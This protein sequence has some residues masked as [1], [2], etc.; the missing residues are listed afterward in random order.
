MD[1][2]AREDTYEFS[3]MAHNT[4]CSIISPILGNGLYSVLLPYLF[5]KNASFFRLTVTISTMS[6]SRSFAAWSEMIN[7]SSVN[8]G[9]T[10]YAK[11]ILRPEQ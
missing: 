5:N 4:S 7:A 3:R 2:S 11:R 9:N 10:A 1:A 8:S 6:Y